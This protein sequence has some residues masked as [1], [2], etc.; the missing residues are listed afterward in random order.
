MFERNYF[1]TCINSIYTNLFYNY[2]QYLKNGMFAKL[3]GGN[4][5]LE[6]LKKMFSIYNS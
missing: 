1:Q 3:G 5:M 4:F 6:F 2:T